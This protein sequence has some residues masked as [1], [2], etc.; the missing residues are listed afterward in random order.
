[1][2]PAASDDPRQ[3]TVAGGGLHPELDAAVAEGHP[4][5]G[6]EGGDELGRV[7]GDLAPVAAGAVGGGD[8]DGLVALVEVDAAVGEG[9]GPH[10]GPREVGED[11]DRRALCGRGP[12]DG[13]DAPERLLER[14]VGK[15]QAGHVHARGDHPPQRR[16]GVRGRAHRR[17]DLRA[18]LGMPRLAAVRAAHIAKAARGRHRVQATGVPDSVPTV[19]DLAPGILVRA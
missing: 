11:T 5:A 9:R 6:G 3:D 18:P 1:L 7:E 16:R 10:L 17:H 8:E 19:G 12:A 4:V 13:L 2:Y 15:G 14:P